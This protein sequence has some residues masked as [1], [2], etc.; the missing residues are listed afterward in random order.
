MHPCDELVCTIEISCCTNE[1]HHAQVVFHILLN[2]III[3]IELYSN[4]LLCQRDM[5]DYMQITVK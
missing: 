5:H 1:I 3:V 4:H 2:S